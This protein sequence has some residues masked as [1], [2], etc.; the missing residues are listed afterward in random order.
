[1]SEAQ[2]AKRVAEIQL[3]KVRGDWPTINAI[4]A[5][6][7]VQRQANHFAERLRE[8]FGEGRDDRS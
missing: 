1:M 3:A 5:P 4:V 8:M 2:D 7:R 6:L